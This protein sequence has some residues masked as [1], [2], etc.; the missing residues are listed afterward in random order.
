M[1]WG[2]V[3][4]YLGNGAPGKYWGIG[5]LIS[6]DLRTRPEDE[7]GFISATRSSV[8]SLRDSIRSSVECRL[9]DSSEPEGHLWHMPVVLD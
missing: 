5:G 8:R 9:I 2:S 7:Q 4:P 3:D 1:G 6:R